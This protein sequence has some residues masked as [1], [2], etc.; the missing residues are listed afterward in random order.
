MPLINATMNIDLSLKKAGIIPDVI[1]QD[2]VPST[3]LEINYPNGKDVALGNTLSVQD[4]AETPRVNFIPPE[5]DA[6]Y[7]LVMA[8]PDAPSAVDPSLG[9]WRH[10]VVTNIKG[11]D[12]SN[13]KASSEHTPYMG[14]APPQGTGNHRYVFLLYKQSRTN[15]EFAAMSPE[16]TSVRRNFDVNG[17]AAENDL[18]LISVNY[19][20]CSV[21]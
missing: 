4:A 6:Q 7:T 15:Q 14:P 1:R 17:F 11:S 19:F 18:E 20:L 16:K 21:N 13:L 12:P 9:P 2:F 8:D 5:E 10:W 3:L